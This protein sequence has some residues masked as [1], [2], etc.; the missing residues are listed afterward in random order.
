MKLGV[1]QDNSEHLEHKEAAHA[2]RESSLKQ[3]E[4][5]LQQ[6]KSVWE[7]AFKLQ[8]EEIAES[9]DKLN[10]R[11]EAVKTAENQ[12][13]ANVEKQRLQFDKVDSDLHEAKK[14]FAEDIKHENS[15][16][17]ERERELE[18]SRH[19][20][21]VRRAVIKDLTDQ[22][23]TLKLKNG[24]PRRAARGREETA[25]ELAGRIRGVTVTVVWTCGVSTMDA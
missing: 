13:R 20:E 18:L 16:L 8:V 3:R 14:R 19:T 5:N 7:G 24:T 6:D 22:M 12:F 17:D 25:T 11:E 23:V 15:L 4:D 9:H 21:D 2:R 1:L 10:K